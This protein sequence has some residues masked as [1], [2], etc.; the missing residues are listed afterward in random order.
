MLTI[1]F[2]H[3]WNNKLDG[4]V[5]TT[6]RKYD[7]EK[8]DYYFESRAKVFTVMLDNKKYG[9]AKLLD[10]YVEDIEDLLGLEGWLPA[11]L[12]KLDTG[13]TD[14]CTILELFKKFGVTDKVIIL[15]FEK[16]T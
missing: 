2:V 8:A 12:L 9:S 6:I 1:R 16:V 3:N 4:K 11:L 13:L 5:F 10:V 15:L 7:T 14:L